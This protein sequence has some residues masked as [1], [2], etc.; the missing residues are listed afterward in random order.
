[1]KVVVLAMLAFGVATAAR[2]PTKRTHETAGSSQ[3]ATSGVTSLVTLSI[4]I[5]PLDD[6][7]SP[8]DDESRLQA[9]AAVLAHL[10]VEFGMRLSDGQVTAYIFSRERGDELRNPH[11]NGHADITTSAEPKAFT[12]A[13]KAWLRT[14]IAQA[15][16]IR[17]RLCVRKV[18]AADHDYGFGYDQKQV[19]LDHY[20]SVSGGMST[21]QLKRTHNVY[22][23]KAGDNA[24]AARKINKTP[25]Q[26]NELLPFKLGNMFT[27]AAW[28]V[29]HHSLDVLKPYLTLPLVIAWALETKQYRIDDSV[30]TGR[31]GGL[32]LDPARANA[33]F[34]LSMADVSQPSVTLP[35][36][37]AVLFGSG[38]TA[39]TTSRDGECLLAGIPTT[40]ELYQYTLEQA[41]AVCEGRCPVV[42]SEVPKASN[43]GRFI[44]IDLLHSQQA[45]QAVTLMREAGL[46]GP[47]IFGKDQLPDACGY[48]CA[49]WAVLLRTLG[50]AFDTLDAST[51]RSL[52]T[53][54]FLVA[55]N[56]VLSKAST[57]WLTDDDILS[58]V[59]T[60]NPDAPNSDPHWLAGPGP[61]N[62]WRAFFLRT[63][64]DIRDQGRVHIMVVNSV[65]QTALDSN[66]LGGEHWFI[67]AWIVERNLGE[68]D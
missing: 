50:P 21:A 38:T 23:A 26:K 52:N 19:G 31:S 36:I 27:L 61:F 46:V 66:N 47:A 56:N 55:Q 25:G 14:I 48:L 30:L 11:I 17:V 65:S 53:E 8:V 33:F 62:F 44:V 13:E 16:D 37:E 40:T 35:L 60:S 57:V 9:M 5:T 58:L 20:M 10:D 39:C 22:L 59:T 18:K 68:G 43:G 7:S 34:S 4:T 32:T 1:M 42:T 64:T 6:A 29:A 41:K 15:T 54:A 67:V 12:R 63:L 45:T 49:G 2:S 51:A 24:W 3:N 28:F